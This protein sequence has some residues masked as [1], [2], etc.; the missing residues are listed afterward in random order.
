MGGPRLLFAVLALL[1]ILAPATSVSSFPLEGNEWIWCFG[2]HGIGSRLSSDLSSSGI[3]GADMKWMNPAAY[4]V[5]DSAIA[6]SAPYDSYNDMLSGLQGAYNDLYDSASRQNKGDDI[7]KLA[8]AI[9][10]VGSGISKYG[11]TLSAAKVEA[12]IRREMERS[13][14]QR[15]EEVVPL[16]REKTLAAKFYERVAD[17]RASAAARERNLA[18]AERFES[19][20]SGYIGK[21]SEFAGAEHAVFLNLYNCS[22][23]EVVSLARCN[24]DDAS[25][26]ACFDFLGGCLPWM[27]CKERFERDASRLKTSPPNAKEALANLKLHS[28]LS[29]LKDEYS[30]FVGL[31]KKA[32]ETE[33]SLKAE[34][35]RLADSV[36]ESLTKADS[37]ELWLINATISDIIVRSAPKPVLSSILRAKPQVQLSSFSAVIEKTK[38]SLEEDRKMLDKISNGEEKYSEEAG[39]FLYSRIKDLKSANERLSGENKELSEM[40]ENAVELDRSASGAIEE[41]KASL[42]ADEALIWPLD[43]LR[44]SNMAGGEESP[45]GR[46]VLTKYSAILELERI[47]KRTKETG[48]AAIESQIGELEGKASELELL[49]DVAASPVERTFAWGMHGEDIRHR[50]LSGI[51]GVLDGVGPDIG[52]IRKSENADEKKGLLLSLGMKLDSALGE[53]ERLNDDRHANFL[54]GLRFSAKK[55]LDDAAAAGIDVDEAKNKFSSYELRFAG[56]GWIG[57]SGAFG[58]MGWLEGE[59]RSILKGLNEKLDKSSESFFSGLPVE[60]SYALQDSSTVVADKPVLVRASFA[61]SNPS[62]IAGG[63]RLYSTRLEWLPTEKMGSKNVIDGSEGVEGV[64][65]GGERLYLKVKSLKAHG[66]ESALV[67][68]YAEPPVRATVASKSEKAT[69]EKYSLEQNI[70]VA[71]GR[72]VPE[73]EVPVRALPDGA[74]M[75]I[76]AFS[77]GRALDWLRT[78][79]GIVEVKSSCLSGNHSIRVSAEFAG[80][81]EVS[82]SRETQSPVGGGLVSNTLRLDMRNVLPVELRDVE[83]S[84]GLPSGA[85]DAKVDGRNKNI[86][87]GGALYWSETRFAPYG[88]ESATITFSTVAANSTDT[89]LLDGEI[90]SILDSLPECDWDSCCDVRKL[91]ED[92]NRGAGEGDPVARY[93]AKGDFL[94]WLKMNSPLIELFSAESANHTTLESAKAAMCSLKVSK[95]LEEVRRAETERRKVEKDAASAVGTRSLV[96][97]REARLLEERLSSLQATAKAYPNLLGKE[98]RALAGLKALA[99]DAKENLI[100]AEKEG[101]ATRLSEAETGLERLAQEMGSEAK[102]MADAMYGFSNP[103]DGDGRAFKVTVPK[104]MTAKVEERFPGVVALQ[105]LASNATWPPS[106]FEKSY[107]SGD[108][109]GA[110]K[111]ALDGGGVGKR[112]GTS[113][114][115]GEAN[116]KIALASSKLAELERLSRIKQAGSDMADEVAGYI[117]EAKKAQGEGRFADA[118]YLALY[119]YSKAEDAVSE[120][121]GLKTPADIRPMAALALLLAAGFVIHHHRKRKSG[122]T[123]RP[124]KSKPEKESGEDPLFFGELK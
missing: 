104:N 41:M 69:G 91:L 90:R 86:G 97:R 32:K 42:L 43:R 28:P 3:S 61:V 51:S 25:S 12:S 39:S 75:K 9:D 57:S 110:L 35:G 15:V 79:D 83:M 38:A 26:W 36:E 6:G 72:G 50:G 92:K 93:L 77:N 85:G 84:Y 106:E 100:L 44:I 34:D 116:G 124:K 20:W 95:A 68:Y 115:S 4:V 10:G 62:S 71:C 49:L 120:L 103:P 112:S 88:S 17:E 108:Y 27:M 7:P 121:A 78:A 48:N 65:S 54:N 113:A 63:S 81:I 13:G 31:M 59:Y 46:S 11:E 40:L 87:D 80:P 58:F 29:D 109:E 53:L 123:A 19:E 21:Y 2:K 122:K 74:G 98:T 114:L 96:L 18:E 119:A 105:P 60:A 1:V 73:I 14:L 30:E 55:A 47:A 37:E 45:V 16:G 107:S 33:S 70:S 111:S 22:K 94:S 56:S 82:V 101:N 89:S 8:W 66:T 76:T 52:R 5:D 118:S 117:E 67:E 64:Y 102:K 24:F 23:F 99:E